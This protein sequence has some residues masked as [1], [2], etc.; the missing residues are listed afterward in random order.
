M[1]VE[2]EFARAVL[3]LAWG[4]SLVV[5]VVVFS[6]MATLGILGALRLVGS[7]GLRGGG[8]GW[9]EVSLM[10]EVLGLG[11]GRGGVSMGA[12][13]GSCERI[14]HEGGR[15]RWCGCVVPAG[16]VMAEAGWE[17][18]W[19]EFEQSAASTR[20]GVRENTQ[21]TH[22]NTRTHTHTHTHTHMH[23]RTHAHTHTYMYTHTHTHTRTHLW[24][25]AVGTGGHGD[26]RTWATEV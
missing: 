18:E 10:E 3:G 26:R 1:F 17:G 8:A 13:S 7:G 4:L 22:M 24:G 20:L 12:E 5:A 19:A 9:G 14:E 23:T 15:G 11:T 16:P 25:L 2:P 6:S 21:V